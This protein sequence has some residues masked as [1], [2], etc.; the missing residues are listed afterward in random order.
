[1]DYPFPARAS[2]KAQT[3][4]F[5][6]RYIVRYGNTVIY[7]GYSTTIAN[8]AFEDVSSAAKNSGKV[9]NR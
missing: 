7:S 6:V 5:G 3:T 4:D 8:M 2:I 9:V 1:M